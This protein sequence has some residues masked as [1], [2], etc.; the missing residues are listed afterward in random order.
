MKYVVTF[1]K[2]FHY[3]PTVHTTVAKAQLIPTVV[4]IVGK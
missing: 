4:C 1:M 3:S 2:I